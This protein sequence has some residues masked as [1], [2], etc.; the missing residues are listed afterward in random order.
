MS[1]EFR[2]FK[3][4]NALIS[5]GAF[6][7]DNKT[8]YDCN[9]M[10]CHF[11]PSPKQITLYSKTVL[12]VDIFDCWRQQLLKKK[13]GVVRSGFGLFMVALTFWSLDLSR[14][15]DFPLIITLSFLNST[16]HGDGGSQIHASSGSGSVDVSTVRSPSSTKPDSP[17]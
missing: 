3:H 17:G 11:F 6:E 15:L 5:N 4:W 16:S 9:K 2:W 8:V 7:N 13:I 12:N 1:M 10:L 14:K